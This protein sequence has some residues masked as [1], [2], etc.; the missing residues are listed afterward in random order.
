MLHPQQLFDLLNKNDLNFFAGVPDSLLKDFCAYVSDNVDE[1]N[2]VITPN[3]GNAIA[4][5]AGNYFATKKPGVVYMQNSGLGNCVNPLTS[6]TDKEVYSIPMLLIIGWRFG[7][8]L[9]D[10][11][12]HQRMGQV[13]MPLLHCLGLQYDLLPEDLEGAQKVIQKACNH[14]KEYKTPFA[15]VVRKN[16]F[17]KYELQNKKTTSYAFN[18]E[19]AVKFIAPLLDDND[20]VVS[21]TG[22]TSRELFEY[23]ANNEQGHHRD[24]LTVGS[25]GHS[26][27]IALGIAL[28]KPERNV[29]CFDG[30]GALIMHMG[31]LSSVGQL[32]PKN[33]KHIVFNN[34][35]HDSVG[36]QPTAADVINIPEIAKHNGYK[37]VFSAETEEEIKDKMQQIKNM[38]GP[39][40]LEIRVNKGARKDLG[41][42]TR[43][44]I[45]N[46]NDFMGFLNKDAT[47]L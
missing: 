29:Y 34:F 28:Q 15:L 3:E 16:T 39:V 47:D 40:L 37:T 17:E 35:A 45:Q 41:R 43:T 31:A 21:T 44:P 24:F 25:M 1:K 20:I 9:K 42:P 32:K 38:E 33:F 46:K 27:S 7:P 10:E 6:L 12:Q 2:H 11:P 8:F 36:G 13:T 19:D 22:K 14:M 30:D 23:R 4:L 5:A 18:R 26:S